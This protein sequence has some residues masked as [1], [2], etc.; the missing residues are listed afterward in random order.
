[1]RT[2]LAFLCNAREG[3]YSTRWEMRV[4]LRELSQDGVRGEGAELGEPCQ[5]LLRNP[6]RS[7]DEVRVREEE[8]IGGGRASN[9]V[10]EVL[11]MA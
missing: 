7:R 3:V 8:A 5:E 4:R 11:G 1:M 6:A 10:A 2:T 9:N